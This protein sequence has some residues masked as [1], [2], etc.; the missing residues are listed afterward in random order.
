MER[1]KKGNSISDGVY[2]KVDQKN[3]RQI[4]FELLFFFD[5]FIITIFSL[6]YVDKLFI[7]VIVVVVA[8]ITLYI[9]GYKSYEFYD[10]FFYKNELF[11]A[12]RKLSYSNINR[13]EKFFRNHNYGYLIEGR[14][15][16][17]WLPPNSTSEDILHYLIKKT[18]LV[19]WKKDLM[20]EEIVA[21]KRIKNN[22]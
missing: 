4:A 19:A 7:A 5:F 14:R 2:Y 22:S 6:L 1:Q 12:Q 13:I 15:I 20:T 17:F 21:W 18:G 3:S 8:L 9:Y 10:D 11:N 16:L